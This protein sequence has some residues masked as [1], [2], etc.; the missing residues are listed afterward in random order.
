MLCARYI[1]GITLETLAAIAFH[2]MKDGSWRGCLT[3]AMDTASGFKF[4]RTISA[5]GAAV[6]PLL[7]E[8]KWEGDEKWRRRLV[9]DVRAQ[10]A[11]YPRY[12]QPRLP[13]DNELTAAEMQVLRL[14][15]ADRSNA[16]IGRIMDIKVTTVKTHV[17][18]ILDKL[19]SAAEARPRRRPKSCALFPTTYKGKQKKL[20]FRDAFSCEKGPGS[21]I[22]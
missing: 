13:L 5:F 18:H 1:D 10:A 8:L 9:S 12:L 16:E 22:F 4:I 2:R 21:L 20:F 19:G 17:S 6:L 3:R 11:F 14:M 15:C 7:E